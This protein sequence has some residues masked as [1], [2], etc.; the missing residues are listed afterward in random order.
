MQEVLA[1]R[2]YTSKTFEGAGVVGDF[3]TKFH[4]RHIHYKNGSGEFTDI[5]IVYKDRGSSWKMDEASFH[6]TV[7]RISFKPSNSVSETVLSQE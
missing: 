5:N 6:L 3:A 7:R 2:K 4:P 1:R